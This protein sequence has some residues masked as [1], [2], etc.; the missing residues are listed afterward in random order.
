MPSNSCA[1][2]AESLRPSRLRLADAGHLPLLRY[3][4]RCR[5]CHQR[6]YVSFLKIFAVRRDARTHGWHTHIRWQR[7]QKILALVAVALAAL[8]LLAFLAFVI[9]DLSGPD[10]D[11]PSHA[12]AIQKETIVSPWSPRVPA[13]MREPTAPN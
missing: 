3:P 2:G 5:A 12:L 11:N 13:N 4:V 7:H 1:C 6:G 10:S 8:V 9:F